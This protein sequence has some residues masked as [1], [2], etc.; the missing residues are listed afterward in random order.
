MSTWSQ[1]KPF[2]EVCHR[3][4]GRRAYNALRRDL[5]A[6]RRLDVARM[7]LKYG[8]RRGVQARIARELSVS[9]ATVSRDV[10][11]TL[12]SGAHV[13]Q[14]CGSYK[15]RQFE[16]MRAEDLFGFPVTNPASQPCILAV[17]DSDL[18]AAP[19]F[20]KEEYFCATRNSVD[21]LRN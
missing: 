7:L 8:H 18:I 15:P 4:G 10:Q 6:F 16:S 19:P 1:P 14:H 2:N 9:E 13:C 20:I 12:Y 11:R 5:A 21:P 3:A 17:H